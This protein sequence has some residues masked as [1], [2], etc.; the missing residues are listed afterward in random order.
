MTDIKKFCVTESVTHDFNTTLQMSQ[1][2][3]LYV[4]TETLVNRLMWQISTATLLFNP[5][6]LH[7]RVTK[8]LFSTVVK[9]G[10]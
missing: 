6:I 5:V 7:Q 4:T 1:L 2:A 10:R 9:S 8:N 3:L